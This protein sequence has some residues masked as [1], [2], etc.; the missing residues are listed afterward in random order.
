MNRT[1]VPYTEVD[2]PK[3]KQV[4]MMFDRIAFRY[5]L[6]NR[7]LSFNIDVLWRKKMVLQIKKINPSKIL[8]VATGTADVAI[9]LSKINPEEIIGIDISNEMLDLGRKKIKSHKLERVISLLQAD[10]EMLPFADN[11]FDAVTVA[12]G[13]RNFENLN[14]GLKEIFRVLKAGGLVCILE[15]S[16]PK[17][18]PFKQVFKIYFEKVCPTLGKWITKDRS[19][20]EY[21]YRSV[22]EFPDGR[23]FL[24]IL[25]KNGFTQTK[26]IPLTLGISS[27]YTGKKY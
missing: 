15:F 13:V 21:L 4:E 20:Y 9:Y 6:M 7:L 26:C 10:C 14:T 11:S 24:N 22:N 12:F 27:I 19:A 3:K 8:D 18:F 23:H 25:E 5:D 1:I 2:L 17:Y 16:K